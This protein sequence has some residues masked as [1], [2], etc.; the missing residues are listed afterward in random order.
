M[1]YI[2]EALAQMHEQAAKR[3]GDEHYIQEARGEN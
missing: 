1:G 2:H 3:Q